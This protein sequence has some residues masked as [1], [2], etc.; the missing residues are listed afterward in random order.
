MTQVLDMFAANIS[1][2]V[3]GMKSG[4]MSRTDL[5]A[6]YEKG[7]PEAMAE[8]LLT[9]SYE[10]EMAESL[11]SYKGYEALE[12][13]IGRNLVKTFAGLKSMCRG[14]YAELADIFIAR[15]DLMAVK[16]LL[17]NRHRE[18]DPITGAN[19]L[20]PSPSIPVALQN[21]LASQDTM[22][23]LIRGL[24]AWNGWL[25]APLLEAQGEYA[26]KNDLS[27]LEQALDRR[28]FLGNVRQLSSARDA[29]SHFLKALLRLEIDRMNL[30]MVF[31][32]KDAGEEAEDVVS[33]LLPRGV[34]D[35]GTL[36]NIASAPSLDRAVA[37]L[38]NTPY[39]ELSEGLAYLS[40]SGRYS[41]LER[42]FERVFMARLQRASQ[43]RP[44]GIAILMRYAW[45]KYNEAI[46]LR[47]LAQ[48]AMAKLPRERVEQ[49]LLH[50]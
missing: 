18:L 24:A 23:A 45:L 4:L 33:H 3:R 32:P 9:T 11:S 39:T 34:L 26:E 25:C 29:D 8:Y 19:S 42:Q 5:E 12:D 38:D 1:A 31:A 40:Q 22:N 27:V 30:R 28:Y 17:R 37:F 50:V 49:E 35:V 44:L 20:S 13:A 36:R 7:T 46:N 41:L 15:W 14:R 43:Q 47:M 21:E 10:V 16:A 48:G 2:R 6:L